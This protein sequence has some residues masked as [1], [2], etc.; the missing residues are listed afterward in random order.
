MKVLIFIAFLAVFTIGC[1]DKGET[2]GAHT[3]SKSDVISLSEVISSPDKYHKKD[4]TVKGIVDG[5]CGS[6]CE[7]F[8]RENN[9]VVPIYMGEIKA[10][11]IKKGTPVIV[12][13]SVYK[14]KGQTVLT[15]KGFT[16]STKG[17]K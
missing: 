13:A 8:F 9:D 3:P 6:R 1:G 12:T 17:G 5:Q 10:P 11:L 7:F 2:Y 4:I 15:A 16:L 14:G